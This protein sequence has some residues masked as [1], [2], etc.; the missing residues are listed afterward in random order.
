MR[1]FDTTKKVLEKLQARVQNDVPRPVQGR[2]SRES[3]VL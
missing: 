2:G 1:M 3:L